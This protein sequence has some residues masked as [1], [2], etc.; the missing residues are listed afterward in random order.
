MRCKY[1]KFSYSANRSEIFFFNLTIKSLTHLSEFVKNDYMLIS[2]NDPIM[3]TLSLYNSV[4]YITIKQGI[5]TH[6]SMI[7]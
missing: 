3:S 2:L 6:I 4:C 7:I 1:T 5:L